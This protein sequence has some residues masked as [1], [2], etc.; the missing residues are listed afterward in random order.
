MLLKGEAMWWKDILGFKSKPRHSHSTPVPE[1]PKLTVAL[2][3][4]EDGFIV[5]E[6]I[7]MPGCMSQGKNEKEALD[8]IVDAIQSCLSVRIYELL[9]ESCCMPHN[10]VGIQSQETFQVKPPELEPVT[11]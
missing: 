11:A 1:L 3:Q 8:N 5:A 4:G 7:E 2:R 9:R 10:L 6:C